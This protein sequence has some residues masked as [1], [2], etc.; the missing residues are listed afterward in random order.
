MKREPGFDIKYNRADCEVYEILKWILLK[1]F[2]LSVM[3]VL[4]VNLFPFV[5]VK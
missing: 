5:V 3:N 1:L 2:L 4:F